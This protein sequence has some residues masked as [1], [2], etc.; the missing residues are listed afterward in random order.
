MEHLRSNDPVRVVNNSDRTFRFSH[1]G[2]NYRIGP[3]QEVFWPWTT[4]CHLLGDPRAHNTPRSNDGDY[5]RL[6]AIRRLA[7]PDSRFYLS[8][9]PWDEWEKVR[10]DIQVF[11][12]DGTRIEMAYEKEHNRETFSEGFSSDDMKVRIAQLEEK[13]ANMKAS[14]TDEL[15]FVKTESAPDEETVASDENLP[16][17]SSPGAPKQRPSTR[18][19]PASS[20]S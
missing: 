8:V 2:N 15:P 5:V 11:D 17:D 9:P 18:K 20:K 1:K 14:Q 19:A 10:P 3:G 16:Q 6:T 4:A 7:P 13:L 12:M